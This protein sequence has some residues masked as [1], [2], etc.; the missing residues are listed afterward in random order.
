M[1]TVRKSRAAVERGAD[2]PVR[3]APAKKAPVRR[4]QEQGGP[5]LEHGPAT[6]AVSVPAAGKSSSSRQRKRL[7]KAF[8]RPLDKM[9]K[10]KAAKTGKA[11]TDAATVRDDFR[12]PEAEYAVLVDLKK[13]LAD[14]G[15]KAK[16]SDL[17]RVGLRLLSSLSMEE[18]KA[19]LAKLPP[20]L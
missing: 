19:L 18:I 1:P 4:R 5:T 8:P 12:F 9:L 10:K 15:V 20:A 6:A 14:Q 17:V 7:A 13:Q 3:E 16:K 2:S 11:L